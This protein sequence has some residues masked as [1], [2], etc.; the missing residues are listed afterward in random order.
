[1]TTITLSAPVSG[2]FTNIQEVRDGGA[3]NYS[4]TNPQPGFEWAEAAS[5]I[6]LS[7]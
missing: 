7:P 3:S 6:Y 4:L 5:A 1:M 2:E